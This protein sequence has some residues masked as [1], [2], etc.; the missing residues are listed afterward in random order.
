MTQASSS[1]TNNSHIWG[2]IWR[3]L[4]PPKQANLLWRILNHDIPTRSKLFSKGVSNPLCHTCNNGLEDSKHTFMYCDWAKNTWFDMHLN[5]NFNN[6]PPISISYWIA[7]GFAVLTTN[8]RI[9]SYRYLNHQDHAREMPLTFTR[10]KN[11]SCIWPFLST[12]LK[13]IVIFSLLV[14]NYA[15]FRIPNLVLG[16]A[17]Y[18][19]WIAW[20]LYFELYEAFSN[21]I[22]AATLFKKVTFIFKSY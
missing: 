21:T 2:K 18:N 17:F 22:F 4:V 3:I 12:Y 11:C 20:E 7:K 1:A 8:H 16:I 15:K 10:S 9:L 5:I 13:I 14:N 19:F 6:Q